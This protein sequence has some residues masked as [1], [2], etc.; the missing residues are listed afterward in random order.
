MAYRVVYKLVDHV[1]RH[2]LVYSLDHSSVYMGLDI[3]QVFG[4]L[5]LTVRL[6]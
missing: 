3:F 5:H 4:E 6:S 1:V 2:S